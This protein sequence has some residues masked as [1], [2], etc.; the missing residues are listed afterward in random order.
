MLTCSGT[1]NMLRTWQN[2]MLKQTSGKSA[3][4]A[5]PTVQDVWLG[6]KKCAWGKPSFSCKHKDIQ[7]SHAPGRA[8]CEAHH[9]ADKISS[10]DKVVIRWDRG[11]AGLPRATQV[12]ADHVVLGE[13]A[14]IVALATCAGVNV[15][16]DRREYN[17]DRLAG[18]DG[19]RVALGI[20]EEL[21]EQLSR[22]AHAHMH[23]RLFRDAA[24]LVLVMVAGKKTT[25]DR[26]GGGCESL[27]ATHKL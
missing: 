20:V 26:P 1:P 15:D 14:G 19:G 27:C 16:E 5:S 8:S 25:I 22:L 23:P 17:Q 13:E 4:K 18:V 3:S 6:M 2:V 11:V 12:E 7:R 21:A 9:G 10:S 24:T